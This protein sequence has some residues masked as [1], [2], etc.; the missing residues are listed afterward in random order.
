MKY[1]SNQINAM[2]FLEWIES[3]ANEL[4]KAGY[5][6]EDKVPYFLSSAWVIALIIALLHYIV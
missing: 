5:I 4:N 3:M 2:S 1:T 6:E